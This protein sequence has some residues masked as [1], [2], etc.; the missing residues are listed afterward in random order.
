MIIVQ[1][2]QQHLRYYDF[3][4]GPVTVEPRLKLDLDSDGLVKNFTVVA[5]GPNIIGYLEQLILGVQCVGY[6]YIPASVLTEEQQKLSAWAQATLTNMKAVGPVT[7]EFLF[8][9]GVPICA[10]ANPGRFGREH[11]VLQFYNSLKKPDMRFIA[12]VQV[13]LGRH[14]PLCLLHTD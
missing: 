7:L 14:I 2:K 8:E 12:L 1:N 3:P 11:C 13:L 4:Y 5:M 6:K 10:D 9:D